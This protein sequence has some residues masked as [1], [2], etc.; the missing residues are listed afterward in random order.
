MLPR[1][2][3]IPRGARSVPTRLGAQRVDHPES[4][5]SRPTE[6]SIIVATKERVAVLHLINTLEAGGAERQL[7]TLLEAFDRER[8]EHHV[9]VLSWG[10]FLAE[11]VRQDPTLRFVDF[12]FRHRHFLPSFARVV[13]YQREH[14]ID[15]VH[16]HLHLVGI[17][18]RI[19][20][21]LAGTPVTVYTEHSDV[22]DRPWFERFAERALIPYTSM[23][24]TV[25]EEQR[26][27]TQ[28]LEGFPAQ[29]VLTMSNSVPTERF[30]PDAA[31]RARVREQFGFSHEDVVVGI[32]GRIEERKRVSMLL[33]IAAGLRTRLPQLCVLV[34]GDGPE[35]EACTRLA[36]E[37]GLSARV[38]FA[39]RQQDVASIAKAMDVLAITS[40]WEGLPINMLEAMST[41][42]PV[43]ATAVGA[44]GELLVAA[45]AG[46]TVEV[47]D[48]DGF[49]AALAARVENPELRLR[50]G[51]AARAYVRA[52]H[53]AALN[54]RR[55]EALY[56]DLLAGRGVSATASATEAGADVG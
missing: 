42:M 55:L 7:I 49:A 28:R 12:G 27:L 53:D 45:Q 4:T 48:L 52:H 14:G 15:V 56:L 10:G 2:A 25:S 54:C 50:E 30:A 16:A 51:R 18:A 24:I 9:G 23:K 37:L 33:R 46:A 17:Y 44:I 29:R 31:V 43:V 19:A 3:T 20:A 21:R 26:Q 36:T 39:G 11:E 35:R 22:A 41:A 13:R 5:T 32:V 6:G 34:V 38:V 1:S 8:F 40:R 47:D